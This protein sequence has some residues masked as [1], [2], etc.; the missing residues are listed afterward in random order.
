M[1]ISMMEP[2]AKIVNGFWPLIIFAKSFINEAFITL[3][4]LYYK[5]HII[6]AILFFEKHCKAI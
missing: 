4:K 5:I 6:K 3:L 2:F 1:K